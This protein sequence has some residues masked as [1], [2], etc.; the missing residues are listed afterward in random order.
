M[1]LQPAAGV[2]DLNPQQ[3]ELNHRLCSQL[4]TVYRLWGYQEVAPP[5]IERLATLLAGGAIEPQSVIQVV[6]D[7]ALGLRPE[8]TASVVR[9]SCTGMPGKS[10]PL[11][12][13]STGTI[14][15]SQT[16][17]GGG[18]R[19]EETL[20][21]GVEIVGMHN[22]NSDM[23]LLLLL[24][25]CLSALPLKAKHQP[26][27]LI[28]HHYIISDLLDK[29][30]LE[31]RMIARDVLTSFDPL[32]I[33]SLNIG[34]ENSEWLDTILRMR[35]EPIK[36]LEKLKNLIGPTRTISEIERIFRSL[37]PKA[38]EIGLEI[39]FDPSFEPHLDLYNGLV[40]QIVCK[41]NVA[42]VV[43]ANGGR[44]DGLVKQ[45][46]A[47]PKDAAGIGFS[48][49]IEEIRELISADDNGSIPPGPIL[50][51][52]SKK[53]NI[54]DAFEYQRKLHAQGLAAEINLNAC[55]SRQEAKSIAED[56]D[57]V[58]MEW[59]DT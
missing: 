12:L 9:A 28:G 42:P 37:I 1:A 23:E 47:P 16:G 54:E 58:S 13:W 48:F 17:A 7:E 24:V 39:Q 49:A 14:F 26:Q 21:S 55:E 34:K 11:R 8:M 50:I 5:N 56:R 43:I 45:F 20:Q 25:A 27:L 59:L 40:F 52:Y 51:A 30:P 36:L 19:I 6:A 57:A 32:A 22:S 46:G 15:Q 41:G 29:I 44:Y 10:R 53:V 33:E 4:A 31:H 3:V 38:D 35:G 2:R 18:L